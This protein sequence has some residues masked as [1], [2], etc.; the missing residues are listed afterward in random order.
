MKIRI[1]PPPTPYREVDPADIVVTSIRREISKAPGAHTTAWG[2]LRSEMQNS[3]FSNDWIGDY[4]GPFDMEPTQEY[5]VG[6][7]PDNGQTWYQEGDLIGTRLDDSVVVQI[8]RLMDGPSET[9]TNKE[10]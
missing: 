1:S 10:V 6:H 3:G 9:P 7:S 4:A 5:I 8:E 2:Y